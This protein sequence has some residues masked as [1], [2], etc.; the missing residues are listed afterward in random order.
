MNH[1]KQAHCTIIAGK[2]ENTA[3]TM[4]STHRWYAYGSV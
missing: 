1:A 3:K 4:R 2:R